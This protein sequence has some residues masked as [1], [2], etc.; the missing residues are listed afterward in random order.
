[1]VLNLDELTRQLAARKE[2]LDR[3]GVYFLGAITDEEAER[4]CKALLVM[5]QMR[6]DYPNSEITI[7]INSGGGSV[8][9]G[10]AIIE[11]MNRIKRECGVK[12]NTI[13]LGYA[14]SMGAIILQAGDRRSM[15]PLSTLMLHGGNWTI[16]GEERAIFEDYHKLADHYKRIM[17]EM[18]AKRTGR[19]TPEWWT[20]YIYSGRERFLSAAECLELGLI[21]EVA[22]WEEWQ[23]KPLIQST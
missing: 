19:H 15:G 18:F 2:E 22:G 6:R 21:D 5:G 10:L 7:Y 12:I 8:G 14:Y 11:M 17:G 3:W 16:A 4:F 20:G 23:G 9:A 13:V 1:M